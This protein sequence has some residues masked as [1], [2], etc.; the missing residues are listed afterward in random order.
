MK[1]IL[2]NRI[3]IGLTCI[4]L[5][6]IIC[7]GLTPMFN[8]ALKSKVSIVR[9]SKDIKEG[10]Q[11]TKEMVTT[12]EA[13]GY[14]L[15]G[16][17]VYLEEDVIGKYANTDLYPGDSILTSKLSDT[18]MLK[19]AYLS[20]LNG[21]NRAIS[22]SIKSFAAGLSGKLEA[23]DIVTLIASDVGEN[24]ETLVPPEL[25]YVEIIATTTSTGA[26]Q[27]VQEETEDGEEQE[28]ASAITV[29]A[30]QEQ[31]TLLA[32]LEQTG[33]IHAALVFRGDSTTAQKFLDEQNKVLEELLAK[34]AAET[35]QE[36]GAVLFEKLGT[37]DAVAFQTEIKKL[38][39]EV[40]GLH[41]SVPVKAKSGGAGKK[42]LTVRSPFVWNKGEF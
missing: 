27:N 10:D 4:I 24:R 28:L 36:A 22:I 35:E 33:S 34:E 18:P 42:K 15:P 16:N 39:A 7:F 29:L 9:V 30:T 12:V 40:F 20:K 38:I 8:N 41:E 5:S 14:N 11:I 6:L 3:V 13:G 37:K 2:Q 31:A 19:N 25:Q 1:K 26:D 32:E 23:G 21:E 17:V